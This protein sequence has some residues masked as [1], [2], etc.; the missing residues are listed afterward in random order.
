ME[1]QRLNL[2]ADRFGA[3]IQEWRPPRDRIRQGTMAG[4][5]K[6]TV[7]ICRWRPLP[8]SSLKAE[9]QECRHQTGRWSER[10]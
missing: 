2:L 4:Q 6:Q 3:R 8:V 9:K 1:T 5:A 7:E 10:K